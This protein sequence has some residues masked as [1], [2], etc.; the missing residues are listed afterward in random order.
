MAEANFS[1][2]W[3]AWSG[4]VC[5]E[6]RMRMS[7]VL[8]LAAALAL[9][10]A[11]EMKKAGEPPTPFPRKG[12]YG[13]RDKDGEFLIQPQFDYAGEFSEGSKTTRSLL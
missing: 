4:P 13:Y 7:F 12:K 10:S 11:Q 5:Y 2:A 8:A 1:L 9:G 3:V 6:W